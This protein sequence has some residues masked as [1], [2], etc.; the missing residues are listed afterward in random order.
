MKEITLNL[1]GDIYKFLYNE[2]FSKLYMWYEYPFEGYFPVTE[3]KIPC[4]HI[5][6]KSDIILTIKYKL[7]LN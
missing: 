6:G 5:F 2:D 4:G 7:Q 3:F 1:A